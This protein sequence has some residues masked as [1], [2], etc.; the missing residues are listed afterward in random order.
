MK[1]L[2]INC[3][4]SSLKYQLI[5]MTDE[6]VLCKGNCERIAMEGSFITHK[7]HDKE[8]REE[9]PFP[10]HTEAFMKVVAMM[11]E[12]ESAVVKDKSEIT[13]I[14]H[15]IVQGAEHFTKS[16]LVTDAIIDKIEEIAPLAPVHNLAHVQ[17]LRSA[18]KVFGDIPNV[19]VFDTTFHQT[20]PPK[21][22]M[23]AIPYEYYEKYAI[24]RYGA[25]GTSHRYVS[26]KAAEVLGKKPS[27]VKM[28]TCHLG[29]GSSITAVD[30]GK[31]VDTSMGLTP[32][33]G[34]IM[35]TRCGDL[36]PSVVCYLADKIDIHGNDMSELLNK[37]SGFLGV[38]GISSDNRDIETAAENGDKR[39]QLVCDMLAYQI[40]K[41]IGSYTAAMNGLDCL[42]FTGGIGENAK[43]VRSRVCEQMSYLGIQLDEA[44]NQQRG[45]VLDLTAEGGKVKILVVCTNEELMIARDT[46]ALVQA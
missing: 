19:V 12:G 41:Y 37:K 39:A 14:G 44:K 24:R 42:V 28:I 18:K 2:V 20:M 1:V 40:K 31:C 13:A 4:S 9:M 29:N 21:A 46:K 25:H 32:L 38:S 45:D 33:A 30:G 16:E 5:D 27:E 26:Q 15:R 10:T 8:W 35:G 6:S 43:S 17:G 3:G 11:T 34:L 22:Y 7:A 23:Y 36:D